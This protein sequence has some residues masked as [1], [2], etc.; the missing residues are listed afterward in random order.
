MQKESMGLKIVWWIESI[1]AIRVLLFTVP[2]LIN[3]CSAKDLYFDRVSDWF[4]L[5][6]TFVAFLHFLGAIA[7]FG[8]H[9]LWKA[10]HY[11][12]AVIAIV[13][14]F[15]L[16]RL[17]VAKGVLM[18]PVYFFPVAFSLIIIVLINM[19]QKVKVT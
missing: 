14:S 5:I 17:I 11:L 13:L 16:V 18:D 8:K 6:I 19:F 15:A 7:A 3:K 12:T 1:I 10:F 2:V 4:M 9:K